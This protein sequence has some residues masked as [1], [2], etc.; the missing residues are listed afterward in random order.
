MHFFAAST[1]AGSAYAHHP[2]GPIALM[3]LNPLEALAPNREILCSGRRATALQR[4]ACH[5]SLLCNVI[6]EQGMTAHAFWIAPSFRYDDVGAKLTSHCFAERAGGGASGATLSVEQGPCVHMD[7]NELAQH[8]TEDLQEVLLSRAPLLR[9]AI[10]KKIPLR[11][12]TAISPD[13][14]LQEVWITAFGQQ[15][16]LTDNR[17]ESV[18]AWLLSMADR[19]LI[20]AMRAATRVKRGDRNAA[21]LNVDLRARSFVTL[22]ELARARNRTPS[23]EAAATEAVTA[24]RI[25]LASMPDSNRRALWLHYIE[26]RSRKQV[27]TLM[28]RTPS[29]VN[30][31]LFRGLQLL[32]DRMGHARRFFSDAVSDDGSK[33]ATL[34]PA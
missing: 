34:S 10:E 6:D 18:D 7:T 2:T 3:S 27:A 30:G 25:A 24:V 28:G 4:R 19:R 32:R 17:P 20:D 23:R 26:G 22:F 31:L 29:A 14:V 9:Q 8:G 13:D 1:E 33:R 11:L 21:A 5:N 16:S 12:R 15:Q